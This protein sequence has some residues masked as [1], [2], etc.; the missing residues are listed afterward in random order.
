MTKL[1]VLEILFRSRGATTP[2]AIC[3][4]L[5]A[6]RWRSTVYS[7]LYRLHKQG[8]LYR[9][10]IAGRL[11]YQISPRGIERLSYLRRNQA[12]HVGNK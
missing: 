10:W 8:L 1:E 11:H 6:H 12:G 7:Y 2:N 4:Q 3:R 9:K 5:T